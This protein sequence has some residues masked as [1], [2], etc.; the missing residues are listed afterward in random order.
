MADIATISLRVNTSELERGSKALDAFSGAASDAASSADNFGNSQKGT[1]KITAEAAREIEEIHQRVREYSEAQ[2][3]NQAATQSATLA[4]DRQKQELQSLLNRISP[5]NRALNDL[6]EL[7]R[8]L[9]GYRGKGMVDDD[10]YARYNAVLETTR[11]KLFQVMEAETAEGRV[12]VEEAKATERA[13]AS[14]KAFLRTLTDQTATFRASKS[15]LAE[16]RAALLGISEEAEPLIAQLREQER[17]VGRE[18][19]QKR[20]AIIA[21]RGLKQALAEQEAAERAAAAEARRTAASQEGFIRSLE[22]QA[23][24]IGKTR[25]ELLA[26]KAA[27]LGVSSQAEPMLIKLRE[28]ENAWKNG[29]ISV[30]QYRQAIRQLPAQFT[31]IATSLAGGMPP[32]LV[33]LQQGGQISDSFGGLGGFFT[34][35]K[36]ELL[37]MKD[38]SDDS[39]ESLS[40]NANALAENAEHA[41]S[42]SSFISPL[43][44]GL[45]ALAV[46]GGVLGYQFYQASTRSEQLKKSL[47][48]TSHYSGLTASSLQ[49]T[50]DAAHEAGVTFADASNALKSLIDAGVPAGTNFEKLTVTISNFADKSGESI[51]DLAQ[52]FA[53]LADDP[54]KGILALNDKYHL[55]TATQY[56]QITALQEQG[57]F[58]EALAAANK[59]A[60]DSMDAAADKMKNSLSTVSRM[61]N[62]LTDMA[63]GMWDAIEG[64][65]RS[66][67]VSE[68]VKRLT[69]KRDSIQTRLNSVAFADT[70]LGGTRSELQEELNTL[71]L[72]IHA[73]NLAADTQ[74]ARERAANDAQMQQNQ[75]LKDAISL[76]EGLNQGLSN[77][78]K[79]ERAITELN[80]M[81]SRMNKAAADHPE[82][83]IGMSDVQY[84]QR[85]ANIKNQYKDPKIPKP[86]GLTSSS[87]D[88]AQDKGQRDLLDLLAQLR[89]LQKHRDINDVVS[90]QRLDLHKAEN[91][92][93]VLEDAA[94]SRQLTKQEQSLLT[95]KAQVLQLA[96]QKAL[97][98]DQIV[99]QD[100]LNKRMDTAQ[101]YA[102][103]MAQKTDALQKGSGMS[104]RLAQRELA[105]SQLASGWKNA[106]G[107]LSEEGYRQEL[108]AAEDYYSA[109]DALRS[110]WQ[111][112]VQK[113]WSDFSDEATNVYGQ[114]EGVTKT[115][116][117]GMSS[118]LTDF[119]TTGKASFKDFLTTF[120]KGIVQ[121]TTQMA[122]LNSMKMVTG[123]TS[124]GA[125]LGFDAGGYTGNGGKYEPKGVVHGGEFVFTREATKRIGVPNLYGMMRGYAEGGYV[126]HSAPTQVTQSANGR[127]PG[128]VMNNVFNVNGNQ[129]Q[130]TVSGSTTG[131][132]K[133]IKDQI[134]GIFS[135][136]LDKALGQSGRIT[137]FVNNKIGR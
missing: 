59:I 31:D 66:T 6:D 40:E 53:R 7:Q 70:P 104:D 56:T 65:G 63:K 25:T 34:Y 42:L 92:F 69:S 73:Y 100:K 28:Q 123:G 61:I 130:S 38:A 112:G 97:L 118:T 120:L 51:D 10:D 19:D 5:V 62:G 106:G 115:A 93:A 3:K 82:Q 89:A 101:K 87:G 108:R 105:K 48:L 27:Q 50:V 20:A 14:Q 136:Q 37:G 131:G 117:T 128:F 79:R 58:T 22:E 46:V 33:L 83:N 2:R 29:T 98:G 119:I 44:V 122:L 11:Q 52:S 72:Q 21:A 43:T 107:D 35:V 64:L 15:D 67:T 80:Q 55:L 114:V 96:R 12:R 1:A 9:V 133:A 57:K 111:K 88:R 75:N 30:G 23:N 60:S 124:F 26:L 54:A 71:N 94:R 13:V 91:T 77:Q 41:K 24:A 8:N 95:S 113:G 99:A 16:Y 47:V 125:L 110:N 32:W 86:T 18:A 127:N 4:T 129:T 78:E 74:V 109:E 121:I 81:R 17:A 36:Q 49:S 68:E 102:N 132:G 85:L 76:Q 90:Q 126:S 134:I 39:S 103:Q 137:N 135:Q 116:F 84:R 45:T